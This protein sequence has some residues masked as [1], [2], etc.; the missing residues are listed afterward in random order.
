M[1]MRFVIR[2]VKLFIRCNIHHLFKFYKFINLTYFKHQ[3]Y[4]ANISL[5]S[6]F[7]LLKDL[8]HFESKD[9]NYS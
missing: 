7:T 1:N 9:F 6:T 3:T 5:L 8:Y 2:P 4:A